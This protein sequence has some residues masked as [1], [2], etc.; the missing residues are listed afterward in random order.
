M[1]LIQLHN[2]GLTPFQQLLGYNEGI[3]LHWQQLGDVLEKEGHLSAPL[4]KKFEKH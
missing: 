3:Q 2:K 1:T 4:K